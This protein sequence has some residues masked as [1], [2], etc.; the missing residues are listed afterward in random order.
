M[1]FIYLRSSN[2]QKVMSPHYKKTRLKQGRNTEVLAN[3]IINNYTI[4]LDNE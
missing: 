2:R 3:E 4:T 1:Q